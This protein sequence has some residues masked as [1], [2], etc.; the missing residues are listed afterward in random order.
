MCASLRPRLGAG[1]DVEED[2]AV[3]DRRDAH[4]EQHLLGF[5]AVE[6]VIVE[7]GLA[8]EVAVAGE[9]HRSF[10]ADRN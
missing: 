1:C 9:Q 8:A 2:A 4:V 5:L 3:E 10:W 6:L 7:L